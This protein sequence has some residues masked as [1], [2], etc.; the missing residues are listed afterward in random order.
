LWLS[1]LLTGC[2]GIGVFVPKTSIDPVTTSRTK[3][4]VIRANEYK[5]IQPVVSKSGNHEVWT[6]RES[7]DWCGALIVVIPLMLPVCENSDSYTFDGN[8]LIK[9]EYRQADFKGFMCS[10]FPMCPGGSDCRLCGSF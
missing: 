5:R 2:A 7:N 4:G 6:Y 8:T 10:M 3:E 1:A 9:R